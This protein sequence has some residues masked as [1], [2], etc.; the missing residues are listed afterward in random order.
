MLRTIR[1]LLVG[2]ALSLGAITATQADTATQ[3]ETVPENDVSQMCGCCRM[4]QVWTGCCWVW[5][6]VC[7]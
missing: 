5:V 4:V 7:Q 3:A 6:Q 2:S 1:V